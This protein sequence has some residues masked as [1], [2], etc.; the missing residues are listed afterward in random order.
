MSD[1]LKVI[2]N[3]QLKH[4]YRLVLL[5][6]SSKAFP[7][8]DLISWLLQWRCDSV[9]SRGLHSTKATPKPIYTSGHTQSTMNQLRLNVP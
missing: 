1:F 5:V 7:R 4:D 2:L 3:L 6:S 9:P 8:Y